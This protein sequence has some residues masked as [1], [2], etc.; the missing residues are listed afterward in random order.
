[1]QEK[2]LNAAEWLNVHRHIS[3]ATRIRELQIRTF[4][5]IHPYFTSATVSLQLTVSLHISGN[6]LHGVYLFDN[7]K[8]AIAELCLITIVSKLQSY[9]SLIKSFLPHTC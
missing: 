2:C 8:N 1:M 5:A 9:H 3:Y 6:W 7:N 4:I